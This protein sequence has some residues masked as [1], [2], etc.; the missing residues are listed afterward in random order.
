MSFLEPICGHLSPKI[1]KVS[2]ELTLR[3]PHE[4]PCVGRPLPSKEGTT[5]KGLRR[6]P[7]SQGQNL[8]LT[9]LYEPHF[10][11]RGT[12]RDVDSTAREIDGLARM[13]D[14]RLPGK[15][16]ANFHGARP[17]HQIITMIK[18]IRTRRLS[19]KNSLSDGLE[20]T[21]SDN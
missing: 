13:V 4:E 3:Y 19:M 6:L 11:D 10:L 9:V 12:Q 16:D 18:W 17:V 1:D 2:E 21:C 5:W 7:E 15:G 14:V 20:P 8:V